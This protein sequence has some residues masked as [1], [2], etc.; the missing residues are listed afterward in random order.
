MQGAGSSLTNPSGVSGICPAGWHMPSEAEWNVLA[1]S[2]GGSASAGTK[3]KATAGWNDFGNGVDEFGFRALPGGRG[4]FWYV[5]DEAYWWTT[6]E[7]TGAFA[8]GRSLNV[9]QPDLIGI[10]SSKSSGFSVRCVKG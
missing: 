1:R 2:V 3:L 4:G 8:W 5:G 10:N 6:G 7:G 9:E